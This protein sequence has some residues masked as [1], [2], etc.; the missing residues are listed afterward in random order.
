[1]LNSSYSPYLYAKIKK[2]SS[3]DFDKS[4]Q[5]VTLI[6]HKSQIYNWTDLNTFFTLKKSNMHGLDINAVVPH[7]PTMQ[8]TLGST[9][10]TTKTKA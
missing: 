6:A 4:K 7:S 5:A 3:P 9:S 10:I 1:M 8:E 2:V